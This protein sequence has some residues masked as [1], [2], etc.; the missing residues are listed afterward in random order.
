MMT[1]HMAFGTPA[2]LCG[3]EE[4]SLSLC[5]GRS[6][7]A[8]DGSTA[9]WFFIF[10]PFVHYFQHNPA[11]D[12]LKWPICNVVKTD[13]ILRRGQHFASQ[14]VWESR[15]RF[16][17]WFG[18]RVSLRHVVLVDAWL[19]WTKRQGNNEWTSQ[20]A[21]SHVEQTWCPETSGVSGGP[22]LPSHVSDCPA[23]SLS[24]RDSTAVSKMRSVG[25]PWGFLGPLPG[26]TG[27]KLFL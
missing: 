6:V 13:T 16:S 3:R 9:V 25:H 11:T 8:R 10:S 22:F 14:H 17:D 4:R 26:S 7:D 23:M 27:S 24:Q 2:S 1:A 21:G 5:R 20:G 19:S 15:S 18:G 12:L